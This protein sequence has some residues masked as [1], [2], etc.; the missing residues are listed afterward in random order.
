MGRT[1]VGHPS[2]TWFR[3][4]FSTG[5]KDMPDM[6]DRLK[7]GIES[8][9]DK[10]NEW[11]QKAG[12]RTRAAGKKVEESKGGGMVEAVKEGVQDVAA[13]ASELAG[14]ATETAKEWASSVGD[15]AV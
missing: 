2:V 1:D 3:I 7:G 15:S 4:A 10:A 8:A 12:S 6:K 5:V 11:T 14:K 9:A 13:G